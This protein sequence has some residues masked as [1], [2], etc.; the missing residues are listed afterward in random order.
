MVKIIDGEIVQDDDPR[1]KNR[2]NQSENR[3]GGSLN[4][5][6]AGLNPPEVPPENS[7][8]R[9]SDPRGRVANDQTNRNQLAQSD[10]IIDFAAKSLKIDKNYLIIPEFKAIKLTKSKIGLI[11]VLLGAAVVLV[12]GQKGALFCIGAFLLWKYSEQR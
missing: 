8:S 2:N 9:E 7:S 3:R 12:F 6:I 10:S 5:R 4:S 1:V 11:Y